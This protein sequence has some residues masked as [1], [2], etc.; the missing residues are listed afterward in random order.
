MPHPPKLL[1]FPAALEAA[2]R[3]ERI[4][5]AGWNGRGMWVGLQ[6]VGPDSKMTLPYLYISDVHGALCPWIASQTDI[7][8]EDWTVIAAA[9]KV[10][11]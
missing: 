4:Q 2:K 1:G 3:G 5:R 10:A 7:L 8:A 6:G 9:D 11:I